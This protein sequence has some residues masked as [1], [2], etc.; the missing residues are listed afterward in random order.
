MGNVGVGMVVTKKEW[1][2]DQIIS[3]PTLPRTGI[4]IIS[5]VFRHRKGTHAAFSESAINDN[6]IRGVMVNRS[7]SRVGT[8]NQTYTNQGN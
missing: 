5:L 3:I 1:M 2:T 8:T 7:G 4:R 6:G